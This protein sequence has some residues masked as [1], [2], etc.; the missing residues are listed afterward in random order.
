MQK[1]GLLIQEP[2]TS[3]KEQVVLFDY[4]PKLFNDDKKEQFQV[5]ECYS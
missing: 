5:I 2:N 3:Y 4:Y 1:Y